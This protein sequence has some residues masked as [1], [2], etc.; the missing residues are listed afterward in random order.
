MVKHQRHCAMLLA[1]V[2]RLLALG[3][4]LASQACAPG[5]ASLSAEEKATWL[6]LHA[7]RLRTIDPADGDFSDLQPLKNVLG[8][9]QMV[10]LGEISHG[11]GSTFL[12]KTRL[13][14]FLH[15]EMGFGVLAFESGL[16]DCAKAWRSL[17]AGED[18]TRA[19]QQGVLPIWTRSAQVQPLVGYLGH[20]ARSGHPL[21]LAGFDS[22]FTGSASGDSL[23]ADLDEFLQSQDLPSHE[24]TGWQE[25]EAILQDLAFSAYQSGTKLTPGAAQQA[26]FLEMLETVRAELLPVARRGD[27]EAS[28]WIQLLESTA[29]HASS[30]WKALD[31]HDMT[32]ASQMRD[33]QMGRNLL[34]LAEDYYPGQKIIVW[35][36][37]I[38]IARNL[39]RVEPINSPLG[40][41][42]RG[43]QVMGDVIW[44]HLRERSYVLVATACE[45]AAGPAYKPAE[46]LTEASEG[47][48]EDLL[49][50]SG[51]EHAILDLRNLSNQA[52]WLREP[53]V[54]R[55]FGFE[56]DLARWPSVIDGL[57]FIREMSPSSG[58]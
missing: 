23:V 5:A 10:L 20:M 37:S 28:F 19:F 15:Q 25:V 16:Y 55:P 43:L 54:A 12:A 52:R 46:E 14:Q 36:A 3:V 56:E 33:Q 26:Q 49:C 35:A 51:L 48:L 50:R 6:G 22:Q 18:P 30:L 9:T 8:D 40:S 7:L 11:D 4:L 13:I 53:L 45:G 17:Q 57:L 27:R 24:R 47:S 29:S 21:T 58:V 1:L 32:A 39:G 42:Y 31:S 44:K 38:H 2:A 34:W 41:H